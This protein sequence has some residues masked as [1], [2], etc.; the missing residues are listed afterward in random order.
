MAPEQGKE[1]ANHDIL[2]QA[3]RYIRERLR[4]LIHHQAGSCLHTVSGKGHRARYQ[5]D[6]YIKGRL[7]VTQRLNGEEGAADGSD[8]GVNSVPDR[9]EPGNFVDEELEHEED[10]GKIP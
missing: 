5:G 2:A 4:R 6:D 7:R 8:D 9:V 10:A 1:C 3:Y